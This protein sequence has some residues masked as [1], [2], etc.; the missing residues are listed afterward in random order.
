MTAP[1]NATTS[2]E[3]GVKLLITD[4]EKKAKKVIKEPLPKN[5]LTNKNDEEKVFSSGTAVTK[6][7]QPEQEEKGREERVRA[8]SVP[9]VRSGEEVDST[10]HDQITDGRKAKTTTLDVGE[11]M[12]DGG[13]QRRRRS[14]RKE[15]GKSG[16]LKV[17]Y[18]LKFSRSKILAVFKD[19]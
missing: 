5:A 1:S 7:A 10:N 4:T 18:S 19:L 13:G 14:S 9:E 2:N 17:P 11:D 3:N 15:E 6:E 12:T 8:K 16:S